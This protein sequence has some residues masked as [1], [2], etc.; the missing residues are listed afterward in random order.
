MPQFINKTLLL[1]I[2]TATLV[3]ASS[4]TVPTTVE[5]NQSFT[6]HRQPNSSFHLVNI[7]LAIPS[8]PVCTIATVV[9]NNATDGTYEIPAS[10]GENGSF[11]QLVA[12]QFNIT[13]DPTTRSSSITAWQD[14]CSNFFDLT[15]ATGKWSP[16]GLANNYT[17]FDSGFIPCSSLDCVRQCF[18][19]IYIGNDRCHLTSTETDCLD[20]CPDIDAEDLSYVTHES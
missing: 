11:Y 13:R 16:Y 12:D 18:Q 17:F 15:G 20:A 10:V 7:Y 4:I 6:L 9:N 19:A 5:G 1:I 3:F 8:G 2:A 14:D